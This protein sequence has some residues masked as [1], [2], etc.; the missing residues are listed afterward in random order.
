MADW[1]QWPATQD[2]ERVPLL[3]FVSLG[4][5]SNSKSEVGF[6]PIVYHYNIPFMNYSLVVEKRFA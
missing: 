6:L 4:K 5:D 1:E 2:H 3:Y